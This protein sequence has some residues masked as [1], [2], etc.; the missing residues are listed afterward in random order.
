[1]EHLFRIIKSPV[2]GLLISSALAIA[3]FI[4]GTKS[5]DPTYAVTDTELMAEKTS[6]THK[7]RLVWEDE[8]IENVYS[9]KIIFFNNGRQFIDK[10]NISES[11][12]LTLNFPSGIQ[13]L[14]YKV[15]KTSRPNLKF[16]VLKEIKGNNTHLAIEID[17]DDALEYKD[18]GLLTVLYTGHKLED[19]E[20][21]GRIKG[22]P[23]GFSHVDWKDVVFNIGD[24]SVWVMLL[25]PL[26]NIIAV[27]F[28]LFIKIKDGFGSFR[29]HEKIFF[30]T[31]IILSIYILYD[32][33]APAVL[34]ITWAVV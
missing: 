19:I 22:S 15:T 30:P 8:E 12:P 7:L 10:S 34:G 26:M 13:L 2:T 4:V 27:S 3:S 29:W 1:M 9:Q 32:G 20:L 16:N 14:F 18:G 23:D 28:L 31:I 17:G 11:A 24:K 6:E 21:V 25:A 5:I 33:F